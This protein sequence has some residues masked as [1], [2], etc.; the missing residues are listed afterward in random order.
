MNAEHKEATDLAIDQFEATYRATYPKALDK[1]L[2]DRDALLAH[3]D[4]PTEHWVHQSAVS[5]G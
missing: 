1:I 4:F 2:K 3:F 5:V